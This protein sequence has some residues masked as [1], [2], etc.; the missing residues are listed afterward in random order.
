MCSVQQTPNYSWNWVAWKPRVIR[1]MAENGQGLAHKSVNASLFTLK[2]CIRP[3]GILFTL[4][5][6]L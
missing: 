1:E 4:K 6:Y 3:T 5:R 2:N